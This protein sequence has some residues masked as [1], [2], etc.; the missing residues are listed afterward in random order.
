MKYLSKFNN[1][2]H[3]SFKSRIALIV[4]SAL[5][6]IILWLIIS[7]NI[8]PTAPK[9]I[10]GVSVG[11]VDLTG[12]FAQENNLSVVSELIKKVDVQIKGERTQV[13]NVKAEN[14]TAKVVVDNVTK[15][16]EY[17]LALTIDNKSGIEFDVLE[18]TPA[19]V[20]VDFD[21][22]ISKSFPVDAKRPYLTAGDDVYIDTLTCSPSEITIKGP[23]SQINAIETV[24]AIV[25]DK[26]SFEESFETH[27]SEV[28]CYQADGSPLSQNSLEIPKTD[29]TIQVPILTTKTLDFDFEI[30]NAEQ[31]FNVTDFKNH[32][33]LSSK[34][35]T[36]AAPKG[37]METFSTNLGFIDLRE[38]TPGFT[39]TFAVTLPGSFKNI[40][41]ITSVT[42]TFN[43]DNYIQK[44]IVV[45][46]TEI[47]PTSKP[48][49]YEIFVGTHELELTVVGPEDRVKLITAADIV[50]EVDLSDQTYETMN[51]SHA[52]KIKMEK[53]PNCWAL[54]DGITVNLSAT[55]KVITTLPNIVRNGA[56]M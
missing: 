3:K 51:F 30:R 44:T 56:I 10:R 41:G 33:T 27:T 25:Q 5:I 34:S 4:Y 48:S 14:L 26:G 19:T 18:I 15:A 40:S 55:P 21:E 12:T 6:S 54:N 7:V 23:L 39:K 47:I 31:Y 11:T 49:S 13:G 17:Q 50:V 16:G 36:V 9:T 20:T 24:S 1:I 38:V 8:Y 35:I 43:S 22:I 53:Y 28:I 29:F 45:K 2:I 46:D 32:F 37:T 42:A 52:V